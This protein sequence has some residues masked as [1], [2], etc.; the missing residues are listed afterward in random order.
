M[1]NGGE[2]EDMAGDGKEALQQKLELVK[3]YLDLSWNI[4]LDELRTIVQR[5]S[6]EISSLDLSSL[7]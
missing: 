6:A 5:R 3:E 4:S 2:K 7:K 1:H